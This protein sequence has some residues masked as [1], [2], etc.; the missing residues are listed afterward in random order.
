M[1]I[2]GGSGRCFE[3]CGRDQKH[4]CANDIL[5]G[6]GTPVGVVGFVNLEKTNREPRYFSIQISS[7]NG[8]C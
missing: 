4:L 5:Y 1:R 6:D 2:C 3:L 8:C 7:P